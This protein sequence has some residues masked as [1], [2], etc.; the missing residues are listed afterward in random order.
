MSLKDKNEKKKNQQPL[1]NHQNILIYDKKYVFYL[2]YMI[3]ENKL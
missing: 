2:D 3:L 1:W